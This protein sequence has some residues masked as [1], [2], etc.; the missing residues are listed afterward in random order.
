MS[1]HSHRSLKPSGRL[2]ITIFLNGLITVVEIIGGIFSNSLALISEAIHNLS[3]TLALLLAWVANKYSDIRPNT[4]RTFGYQRLEIISAFINASALT[5]ISIYLIYVAVQRFVHPQPVRSGIMMVIALIGLIANLASM[6]FL[7]QDSKKNLNFKAAYIHLLGDT[8][9]SVAVIGGAILIYFTGVVWIDP[10]LT[11][12]ISVVIIFQAYRILRESV[13]ILMQSTP[14]SVDLDAI[15]ILIENDPKIRNVHHVHCWQLQDHNILFE[16]HI[17]TAK[18]LLLSESLKLQ[19]EIEA[20]LKKEFNISHTTLQFEFGGCGDKSMIKKS[21]IFLLPFILSFFFAGNLYSQSWTFVKEKE[22]IKVYTKQEAGNSLKTFKGIA[23]I[24]TTADKVYA[25]IGNV[26]STDHWD[27]NIKELRVISFEKD[28]SFSYYLIYSV[29]WPL[30]NRDLCV[31]ARITHDTVSGEIVI[32]AQS[33]PM[34]VPEKSDLVRIKN[35][36]QKWTIQQVDR[37]H[38]R[39]I[40]EGYADPAGNIPGWLYNMVITNTPL[41]MISDIRK[42]VQ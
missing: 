15:R 8:L 4:R 39:L 16:A 3:D 24:Q 42:R 9:S 37:D 1:D 7:R 34:L 18:D 20:V 6:L 33:K 41:N 38:I 36:W 31:E 13:D 30:Q 19:K 22:G 23:E 26:K 14:R 11:L 17:E 12:L 40:L 5:A 10:I 25:I 32:Y 2:L 27:E 29:P 21:F 35:Y 28:K